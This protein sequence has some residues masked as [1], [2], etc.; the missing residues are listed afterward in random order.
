MT[1]KCS[2][3]DVLNEHNYKDR[4][5]QYEY[6]PVTIKWKVI[7]ARNVATYQQLVIYSIGIAQ[8]GKFDEHWQYLAH[9]VASVLY[10]IYKNLMHN[11][12]MLQSWVIPNKTY[13]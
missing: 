11:E 10:T 7:K 9:A 12:Q 3:K 1:P 2:I 8:I 13:V 4:S 6:S 5:E